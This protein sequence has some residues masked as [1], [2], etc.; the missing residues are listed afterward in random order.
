MRRVVALLLATV[1]MLIFAVGCGNITGGEF[2]GKWVNAER[3]AETLEI[4]RNEENFIVTQS[5]PTIIAKIINNDEK[6]IK[7][8]TGV[9]KD[10]VL[11]VNSG[12]ETRK[13]SYVKEGGYLLF[14]EHKFIKQE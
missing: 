12:T 5:T 6:I 4:K 3:P 9:L 10:G 13:I 8:Y 2:I 14:E 1:L 11:T 7:E